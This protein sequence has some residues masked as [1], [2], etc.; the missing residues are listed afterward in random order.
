MS[1]AIL[2][3]EESSLN[4]A[5]RATV[6]YTQAPSPLQRYPARTS[7]GTFA[8]KAPSDFDTSFLNCRGKSQN[9][10]SR[11]R[12]QPYGMNKSPHSSAATALRR[13]LASK[14]KT[15]GIHQSDIAR[16]LQK[17]QSFVSKYENGERKIDLIDFIEICFA[18]KINPTDMLNEYL[19]IINAKIN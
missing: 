11:I 17:P 10:I 14:R 12:I 3:K 15:L 9:G 19:E 4:S 2:Q 18:L 8:S 6:C 16:K 1:R 5:H 7:Q 13:L